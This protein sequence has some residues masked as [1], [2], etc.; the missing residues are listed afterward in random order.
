[1]SEGD[2]GA[3]VRG[4]RQR[5]G[6]EART[7][8]LPS[9]PPVRDGRG[10][11]PAAALRALRKGERAVRAMPGGEARECL[12]RRLSGDARGAAG[13]TGPV[14]P[15]PV[16]VG[17]SQEPPS[18][19]G[20]A[21]PARRCHGAP[22][23]SLGVGCVIVTA[24][25]PAGRRVPGGTP[26]GMFSRAST[27]KKWLPA[28]TRRHGN[29]DHAPSRLT[30]HAVEFSRNE[31]FLQTPFE[32]PPGTAVWPRS[33]LPAR[34]LRPIESASGEAH[35]CLRVHCEAEL[36]KPPWNMS[37]ASAGSFCAAWAH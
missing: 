12:T 34:Q 31:C 25:T 7:S 6:G 36:C 17:G 23:P 2:R 27:R 9:T 30:W 15:A 28:T 1:M 22:V 29:G 3:S 35:L 13:R 10:R 21:S 18:R 5:P 8:R 11:Q 24:L 26:K 32:G 14:R 4:E 16:D 20:E 19:R 37:G 33:H